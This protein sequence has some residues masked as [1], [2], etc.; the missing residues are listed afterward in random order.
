[1]KRGF[2]LFELVI[3]LSIISLILLLAFP[4]IVKE[5]L[6]SD[7]SVENRLRSLFST[8]F[9][10]SE[11]LELCFNFKSGSVSVGNET[12]KVPWEMESL[13]LPGKIVSRQAASK[14]CFSAKNPVYGAL[15]C[16]K[17]EEYEA[18]FFTVPFGEVNLYELSEAQKDTLKDKVV[19]GRVTEWFSSFSY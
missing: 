3:V 19:K 15:I 6:S 17:G 18:L 14:F 12:V 7:A 1:M 2:T 9:S 8:S 4:K 13:V 11:P 10:L 5:G 16:K